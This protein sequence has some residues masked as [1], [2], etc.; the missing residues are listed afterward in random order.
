MGDVKRIAV[1]G[2]QHETNTF[3]PHLAPFEAFARADSWPALTTGQ[4]LFETM[5]GLNIPLSGFIDRARQ[6]GHRL[7]PL[8]WCSAEPS[9][10]VTQDAF[11]QVAQVLCDGLR[12]ALP[13]DAVY[14]DLHGAMVTEHHED[15][16]GELL[17]RV[18]ELVGSVL[19]GAGCVVHE[20]ASSRWESASSSMTS[21]L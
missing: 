15:G 14:L 19:R 16:E 4:A 17:R 5:A 1:G 2:F 21:S 12:E 10:Y 8:A 3:A 6:H 9:S 11:E 7:L 18:R 20:A 13:L